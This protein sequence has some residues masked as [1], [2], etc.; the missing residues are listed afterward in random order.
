MGCTVWCKFC[1]ESHHYLD[2]AWNGFD[3]VHCGKWNDEDEYKR[4]ED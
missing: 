4:R 2:D 1:K 3:C